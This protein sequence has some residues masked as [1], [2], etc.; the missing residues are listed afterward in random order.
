ME[1]KAHSVTNQL[2]NPFEE[3]KS[4]CSETKEKQNQINH[5]GKKE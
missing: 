3:N 2:V 1:E 5:T 4:L